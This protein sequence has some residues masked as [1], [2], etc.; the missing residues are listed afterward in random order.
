[1]AVKD[2]EQMITIGSKYKIIST[3]AKDEPLISAGEFRGYAAFANETA[4]VLRLDASDGQEEGRI[5]FLPY[6][7]VL[8]IDVL[9]MA[10]K[11]VK[12]KKEENQVYY[13]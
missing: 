3:G 11:E 4:L 5:R 10:S 6:H 2:I 1:M 13:G 12:E 9:E 7:A 8:C